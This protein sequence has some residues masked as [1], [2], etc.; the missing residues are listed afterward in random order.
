MLLLRGLRLRRF[1]ETHTGTAAV[2]V[3][4]IY[5]GPFD[6]GSNFLAGAFSSTEFTIGGLK[7][8]DGRFR[9]TRTLRKRRLRPSQQGAC[10]FYLACRYQAPPL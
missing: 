8:S 6:G 10:G 7:S 2:V 4:K 5:T 1:S 9:Y 3:D